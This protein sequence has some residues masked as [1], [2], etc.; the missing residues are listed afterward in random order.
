M[1]CACCRF[2]KR[3]RHC[4]NVD[5]N[6]FQRCADF[7]TWLL[8]RADEFTLEALQV[9]PMDHCAGAGSCPAPAMSH[10][11][12]GSTRYRRCCYRQSRCSSLARTQGLFYVHA[13]PS[14]MTQQCRCLA[15][16][17]HMPAMVLIQAAQKLWRLVQPFQK[18]Q[19]GGLKL[20]KACASNRDGYQYDA[21]AAAAMPTDF[22]LSQ[23]YLNLSYLPEFI[24]AMRNHNRQRHKII[25]C[26]HF[27]NPQHPARVLQ[28]A[29]SLPCFRSLDLNL[30]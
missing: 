5:L 22:A 25:Y 1:E 16:Y 26:L 21:A 23:F 8:A 3:A 14:A 4:C 13:P 10:A 6:L 27:Q 7:P 9:R 15:K 17:G 12:L 24:G 19:P 18:L 20:V 2:Q 29:W 30:T 28:H 11:S